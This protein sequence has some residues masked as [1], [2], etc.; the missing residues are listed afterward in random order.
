MR[1]PARLV[2]VVV[3]LAS[4]LVLAACTAGGGTDNGAG[5]GTDASVTVGLVL[6][7]TDLDIRATSGAALDQVLI[8]NVYEG[9]VSRTADGE[10]RPSLATTWDIS[11]D[12]LSYTFHLADGVRFHSGDPM[13]VDD[14]VWSLSQVRDN[15]DVVEHAAFANV[16]GIEATDESTVTLTLSAPDSNLLWNLSSRAGLVL[17]EDATNDLS[18]SANGT[19]PFTLTGWKQG[20][21]ITLD[22]FDDYWGEPAKVSE[23]VFAYIPDFTAAIG[24]VIAGDVDVQTAIDPNLRSQL[25]GVDDV[26]VVEGRTTDKFTLAFNNKRAPLDDVRVR[27]ALRLAIDHQ[28]IID[29]TGGAGVEMGGPIPELD[30]G[31]EDLTDTRPFDPDQARALLAEAGHP[32]LSLTLTMPSFYGSTVSNVLV[33]QFK[34]V[35]VTLTVKNVEFAT[36]LNDVYTNKDY[37]LSFVDHL[38]ARDFGSWAN[39]DYYFGYDNPEVQRLYAESVAAV[40]TGVAAE[41]LK[42]AARIVAED[43]AADW[44]YNGLTLTAIRDGITGFPTDS[45]NARLDLSELAV[46]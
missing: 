7:P 16:T 36:W 2:A 35:G 5:D 6:E 29:A 45:P 41:K 39:P 27:K 23:V 17:E 42:E 34:D 28:A 38:E 22:R 10:I 31:Y 43:H 33:S 26:S 25:D 32:S 18:T 20:D 12:G 46:S 11:D 24:A 19:G 15:A 37:D 4:A 40:D 8:D 13:T 3:A 1:R 30:P 44:L 14:V 9:L 21:S